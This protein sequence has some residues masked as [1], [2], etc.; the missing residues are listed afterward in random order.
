MSAQL[1][2]AS[3]R[4]PLS[5]EEAPDG[6]LTARRGAGG[7]VSA[8]G[9][10]L[11]DRADALWIAA[12]LTPD[13]RR[14][15]EENEG[16][17]MEAAGYRV[18][19]L[20]IPELEYD[21]YYN[22]MSNRFLWFICHYLWDP[23][24]TP[25]IGEEE[26]QSW[27]AYEEVNRRF[28]TAIC[29]NTA[30]GVAVMIQDYH[31]GLAPAMIRTQRPDLRVGIFW[32]IPFP[33]ADYLRL[34][35]DRWSRRL[36]EGMLGADLIGFHTTRWAGNFI[37]AV[38][39][40]LEEQTTR[41]LVSHQGRRVRVGHYP[42]GVD[43]KSLTAGADPE[44]VRRQKA[45][46][47]D[48]LGGRKLIL[49]VDRTE[50]SKNIVRGLRAYERVLEKRPDLHGKVSHLALLTPSRSHVPEYRD[51]LAECKETGREIAKRFQ[52]DSWE[53]LRVEVADD[54]PRTLAAYELYDVLVV[55][56]VFD[57][58]NLVAR[59]GPV[60]NRNQGILVLSRNAGAWSELSPAALGVNPFDVDGTAEAIE[61][62]I[63]LP[64]AERAWMSKGVARLARGRAPAR[65][66]ERQL[67][68][69]PS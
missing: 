35:P 68:D 57:G 17:I 48:W 60:L 5:Y 1:V 3:N 63:D 14:A 28:A 56:P 4:G 39:D 43:V 47:T 25:S 46:I 38:V 20:D 34:M 41:R 33:D 69:L 27:H 16:G 36:L 66:L 53:P 15:A 31:L 18:R 50:L 52:T 61:A 65:W 10:A 24:H 21:M 51:Y 55:N 11:H 59:E 22:V 23:A 54:F 45:S 12:A 26:R 6:S 13:D 19:L 7:L 32:H 37:R 40:V 29:D 44:D 64:E 2:V 8:L 9:G 30:E 58:M 67:R 62:A 42:V 49:R